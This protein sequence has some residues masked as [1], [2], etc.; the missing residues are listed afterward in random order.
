MN[1]FQWLLPHSTRE[2]KG[3]Q[4]DLRCPYMLCPSNQPFMGAYPPKMKFNEKLGP[5]VYQY[6]CKSCGCLIS[7]SVRMDEVGREVHK[8][9]PSFASGKPSYQWKWQV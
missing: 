3:R 6:R 9:E 1:P 4:A 2:D 8:I 7:V 5:S